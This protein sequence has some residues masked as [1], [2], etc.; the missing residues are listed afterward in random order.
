[1][2]HVAILAKCFQALPQKKFEN[3]V[4]HASAGTPIC[5]GSRASMLTDGLGGGC[6]AVLADGPD[7]PKIMINTALF[8]EKDDVWEEAAKLDKKAKKWLS[9][10]MTL[11]WA[12]I[13]FISALA[14]ADEFE[15]LMAIRRAE[16]A[17]K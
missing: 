7:V 12:D 6:P 10:W 16:Q 8:K 14:D 4:A 9:N 13:N 2:D 17:K 15:V 1:M 5:C 3:L 11:C